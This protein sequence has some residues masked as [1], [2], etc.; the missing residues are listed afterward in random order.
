MRK[1]RLIV[2]YSRITPRQLA[3]SSYFGDEAMIRKLKK[4]ND[5]ASNEKTEV[6]N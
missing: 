3:S 2:P 6:Y 1:Q 4:R 5:K